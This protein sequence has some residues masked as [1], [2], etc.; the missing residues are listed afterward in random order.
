MNDEHISDDELDECVGIIESTMDYLFGGKRK[1][2]P[3]RIGGK[4]V[5]TDPKLVRVVK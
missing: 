4:L 1:D 3:V 5:Y 2:K